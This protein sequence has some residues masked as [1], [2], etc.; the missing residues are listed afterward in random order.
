MTCAG[1]LVLNNATLVYVELATGLLVCTPYEL[2]KSGESSSQETAIINTIATAALL[3]TKYIESDNQR[4]EQQDDAEDQPVG[5]LPLLA[6]RMVRRRNATRANQHKM[7]QDYDAP[8]PRDSYGSTT[9]SS[10]NYENEPAALATPL[11]ERVMVLSGYVVEVEEH[12]DILDAYSLPFSF[13]V[14]T[15]MP[16][17]DMDDRESTLPVVDSF[18]LSATDEESKKKWIKHIRYWR[19][20]GWRD[21]VMIRA[22]ES[23]YMELQD[24]LLSVGKE[25]NRMLCDGYTTRTSEWTQ[26]STRRR[27]YRATGLP[28]LVPPP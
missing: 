21:A 24:L 14:R 4:Q 13:Q 19:R 11:A 23:D 22:E 26:R 10:N 8:V 12:N 17:A 20:Y 28:G 15:R 2:S 1:Y 16:S 3:H 18:I 7:S 25:P 27:F 6:P 9:C 5:G